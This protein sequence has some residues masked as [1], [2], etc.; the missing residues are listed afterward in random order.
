MAL[1]PLRKTKGCRVG[2]RA[3]SLATT[4]DSE[5]IQLLIAVDYHINHKDCQPVIC[6]RPN[7]NAGVCHSQFQAIL[8]FGN[9]YLAVSA[10]SQNRL[11]RHLRAWK[12]MLKSANRN[13]LNT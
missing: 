1:A 12:K 8:N 11:I 4:L 13:G 3:I 6:A 10:H 2:H 7:I 5:H 9:F